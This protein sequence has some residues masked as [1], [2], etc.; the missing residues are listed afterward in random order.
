MAAQ[1]MARAFAN[2]GRRVARPVQLVAAAAAAVVV[3]LGGVEW[4]ESTTAQRRLPPGEFVPF[5]AT[6]YCDSGTTK[7]G[8]RT[9]PGVVAADP[10][11]L[12]VGSVVRVESPDRR[13][14]EGIYTVMDTGGL[15][16]GR[17]IDLFIESCNEAKEFGLRRVHVHVLRAGWSPRASIDIDAPATP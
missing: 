10:A 12:P 11:V 14:Y 9:R 1:N 8:V 5:T 2:A 16:R 6:A 17:R 3:L 7:S 13:R 15:V 4:G